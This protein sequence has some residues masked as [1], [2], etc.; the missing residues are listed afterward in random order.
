MSRIYLD[1]FGVLV[2]LEGTPIPGS[3]EGVTVL[4]TMGYDLWAV[5]KHAPFAQ[6]YQIS[7]TW[8]GK[9]YPELKHRVIVTNDRGLLGNVEDF[10]VDDRPHQENCQQFSGTLIPFGAGFGVSWREVLQV[11]RDLS[12]G[13]SQRVQ[14]IEA[15]VA[16]ARRAIAAPS[17][18]R[19]SDKAFVSQ[20]LAEKVL[21][22]R[23]Y[24][25]AS[26]RRYQVVIGLERLE[27]RVL[28]DMI[29]PD[30]RDGANAFRY[31][32]EAGRLMPVPESAQA[33][34]V[35]AWDFAVRQGKRATKL[36]DALLDRCFEVNNSGVVIWSAD[37]FHHCSIPDPELNKHLAE[38]MGNP[39]R[40][41]GKVTL[42]EPIDMVLHCPKC[43]TQHIDE[44]EEAEYADEGGFLVTGTTWGNPPHRTHL[45]HKCGYHWRPAD[46]PTNGVAATQ[47][48]GKRDGDV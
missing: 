31:A 22:G 11:F 7:A 36:L 46:V 10:L 43:G 14:A 6:E 4:K 29:S 27:A 33:K 42:D 44:P 8:L 1:F 30:P 3:V 9:H 48:K 16:E 40:G 39:F 12:L 23:L 20:E 19:R 47:T 2:D 41:D 17:T 21:T 18:G 26:E 34:R 28:S 24:P 37:D 15:R 5:M 45:C 13:T 38:Y 25:P 35:E 32:I